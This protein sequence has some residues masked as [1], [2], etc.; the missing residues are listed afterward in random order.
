MNTAIAANRRQ[1]LQGSTAAGLV[2][3]FNVPVANRA[4]AA[5]AAAEFTPN[6]FLR[7]SPDNTVTVEQLIESMVVYGSPR[8]V[9]D[10]LL[11]FR[12]RTGPFG[13]LLMASMDGSGPN[14]AREWETM[15]LLSRDVM[16][17]IRD[18]LR[19]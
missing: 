15:T 19:R 1:F 5:P 8:T 18:S 12:E 16:P 17:A 11:A 10:K 3:A 2:I 14:R 13:G 7:I 6:A 9:T 4:A